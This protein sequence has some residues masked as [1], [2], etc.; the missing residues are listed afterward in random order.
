[1]K[2]KNVIQI[3][4]NEISTKIKGGEKLEIK[5]VTVVVDNITPHP[6]HFPSDKLQNG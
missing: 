1:V 2:Y 3:Y 6:T 4:L 5:L